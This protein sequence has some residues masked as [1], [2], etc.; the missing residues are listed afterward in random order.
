MVLQIIEETYRFETESQLREKQKLI[1]DVYRG[2]V[3]I[4]FKTLF[5]DSIENSIQFYTSTHQPDLLALAFQPHAGLESLFHKALIKAIT[6]HIDCPLIV[7]H[8][9]KDA[10]NKN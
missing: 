5:G 10:L 8:P 9:G 2:D 1:L 6:L 7:F 4:E 3:Q